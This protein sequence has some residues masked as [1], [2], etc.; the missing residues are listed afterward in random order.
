MLKMLFSIARN[1][2][3]VSSVKS[4]SSLR[5]KVSGI[6]LWGCSLNVI[7]LSLSLW[8]CLFITLIKCLKGQ[9]SLGSLCSVV[10]GLTVS[11]WGRTDRQTD[12]QW[13]LL[14]C[15]G[16]LNIETRFSAVQYHNWLA[17]IG[18]GKFSIAK[19]D[20]IYQNL[21]KRWGHIKKI[22]SEVEVASPV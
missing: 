21:P 7:V 14:S 5:S 22:P 8:S 4:V 13:V 2:I 11:C 6:V 3:S 16:Q 10:S 20:K 9:K 15:S 12:R 18:W 19:I 1:V 17:T